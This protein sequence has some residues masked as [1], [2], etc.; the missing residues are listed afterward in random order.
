MIRFSLCDVHKLARS[1]TSNVREDLGIERK[2]KTESGQDLLLWYIRRLV[3]FKV[4]FPLL[5]WRL[6]RVLMGKRYHSNGVVDAV[7]PDANAANASLGVKQSLSIDSRWNAVVDEEL[8]HNVLYVALAERQ[9]LRRFH[10]YSA[11]S[12]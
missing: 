11:V 6:V 7:F 5:L 1:T 2:E 4:D 9:E 12:V 10:S 8:D 3:V